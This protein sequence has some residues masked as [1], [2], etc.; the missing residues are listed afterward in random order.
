[1]LYSDLCSFY[2]RIESLSGRLEMTDQLVELY[3]MTPPELIET[4]V[5][6]TKGEIRPGYEGIELGVAE[7]LA[8]K[9]IY[10]VT[11]ISPEEIE[12]ERVRA[13]DIGSAA[14]NLIGRKK[15][16]A[17][18][19]E[20][21]T[22]ERVFSS[23]TRI[24]SIEGRSSQ[25]MKLKL[26]AELLHDSSP[27]EAKYLTRTVC[28]KMRLGIADMTQIDAFAY[29]HTGEIDELY[30]SLGEIGIK[31]MDPVIEGIGK[32][33]ATPLAEMLESKGK[34]KG[35]GMEKEQAAEILEQVSN[36]KNL[37]QNNREGIVK[38]Y[39]IHPDLGH[40]AVT[41]AMGGMVSIREIG[42]VPG[43]PLR[44]MLGERLPSISDILE[45]M[46][47]TAA[48]EYKYDGLRVQAHIDGSGDSIHLFSRQLEDIT[49]QFPDVV[50]SLKREFK[51][52]DSILEGEC[53]PI[54][55]ASGEMLP[56]QV[57]SQRRGRK[58]ELD[59]KID[60]VPVVLVLFDCLYLDGQTLIDSPYLDR[61]KAI[62]RAFPGS[63]EKMD[64]K[65]GLSLSRME[66]VSDPEKGED[67]FNSAL[68]DGCE[69]IMAK[70][71]SDRSVYQAG[72]RGWLWIKYKKDYRSEL[73]DTLDLV[74]VGAYHG[75]GRRGGTFGALLMAAY[76]EDA[77][78]YRTVC[79]L[80]SGF[81][82]QHLEMLPGLISDI[83]TGGAPH[84]KVDT[85]MPADVFISP[86][87]VLEVK[88]A[89]ITFSPIHTC[90]WGTMKENAGLALRF[91]RFTGRF[92]EDKAPT[93]ATTVKEMIEL[94][95]AQV[96]TL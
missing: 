17:L 95:K 46:G 3:R 32:H 82:D 64:G 49:G 88:G 56:F 93:D 67:L 18:F 80:G 48:L 59:N 47:G 22:V 90:A 1:M 87:V 85:K 50:G 31:G 45:K 91:P 92:R 23:L 5:R 63:S 11:M 42:V 6:L 21:L 54:D 84:K 58:Y 60:E 77:D 52:R 75:T 9:A 38:A 71:I 65:I 2:E 81:N 33:L 29:L 35:S 66:I 73:D 44:A 39:N 27:L 86:Y 68:D 15:Q 96:K 16:T 41:L 69:G 19:H 26:I 83:R 30:S 24:A 8:M 78:M 4:V 79:K 25:D 13:G 36:V 61:R 57:I 34:L 94:Y 43:I 40:I 37:V 74:V 10:L 62:T 70:S 72:S 53:V 20:I 55:P 28:Q 51:G 89:E 76:D 12:E 14:E 7:K